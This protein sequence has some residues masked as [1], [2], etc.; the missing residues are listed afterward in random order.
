V[1]KPVVLVSMT[2]AN[3]DYSKLV[4]LPSVLQAFEACVCRTLALQAGRLMPLSSIKLQLTPGSV[5]VNARVANLD[6]TQASSWQSKLRASPSIRDRLATGIEAVSGIAAACT[7]P[8]SV[9]SFETRAEIKLPSGSDNTLVACALLLATI[10]I[11]ITIVLGIVVGVMLLLGNYGVEFPRRSLFYDLL[12][13]DRSRSDQARYGHLRSGFD[14]LEAEAEH[15][16]ECDQ[17]LSSNQLALARFQLRYAARAGVQRRGS[18]S[19]FS[20]T[21]G[22]NLEAIDEASECSSR[23]VSTTFTP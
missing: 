10:G 16:R 12:A 20:S 17:H 7:G 9:T 19:P 1:E 21:T 2:V 23:S 3:V 14:D 15:D 11:S 18:F 13:S 5:R 22:Q 6:D 8:V 4:V